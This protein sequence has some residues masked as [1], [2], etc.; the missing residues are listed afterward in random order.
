[1]LLITAISQAH[2]GRRRRKTELLVAI[3]IC[4]EESPGG[5]ADLDLDE[6]DFYRERGIGVERRRDS[7]PI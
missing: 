5:F 7:H 1:V 4:R 6:G 3:E 2:F